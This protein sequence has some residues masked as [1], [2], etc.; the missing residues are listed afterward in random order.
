MDNN[1]KRGFTLIEILVVISIIAILA[2]L[3][4]PTLSRAREQARRTVCINNIKQIG[5]SAYM[6]AQNR[7]GSSFYEDE[8]TN[9]IWRLNSKVSLG[10][11]IPDFVTNTRILYCPSQKYYRMDN[12]DFGIQNFGKDGLTSRS[13]YYVRGSREVNDTAGKKALVSDVEFPEDGKTSH[14]NGVVAGYSDGSVR[15]V[16]N[17]RRYAGDTWTDYWKRLDETP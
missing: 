3:L 9:D 6:F 4:L 1:R 15:W 5:L 10:I 14:K 13:S 2:A 17:A 8:T 7:G 12:P 11:L 16:N